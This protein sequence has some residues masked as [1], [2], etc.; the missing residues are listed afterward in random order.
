MRK[1]FDYRNPDK[2]TELTFF[3]F[4]GE[5]SA[6]EFEAFAFLFNFRKAAAKK[7]F[8]EF[9]VSGDQV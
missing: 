7:L 8:Q 5:V 6:D 4:L 3:Y 2:T 1:Y 9:D